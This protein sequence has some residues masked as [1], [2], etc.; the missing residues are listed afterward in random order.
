M[1]WLLAMFTTT[2]TLITT[3]DGW[4]VVTSVGEKPGQAGPE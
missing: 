2:N 3:F 4:M 1:T